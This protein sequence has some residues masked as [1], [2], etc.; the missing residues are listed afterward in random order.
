VAQF[1]NMI[2][3]NKAKSGLLVVLFILLYTLLFFAV[4]MGTAGVFLG[5]HRA[6]ETW[7]WLPVLL[8]SHAAAVGLALLVLAA[9][10]GL[11]LSSCR[12]K[13]VTHESDAELCNILQEVSLAA[14]VPAP[15]L[16]VIDSLSMNALAAGYGRRGAV[17]AVTSGLRR[18]LDRD[19]LQA[20][21]AYEVARIRDYDV[22]LMTLTAGFVGLSSLVVKVLSETYMD[23]ASTEGGRVAIALIWV[24]FLLSP[25]LLP[26]LV[27][28]PLAGRAIQRAVSRERQFLADV[29]AARLTRYPEALVRAL[30]ILSTDTEV[31]ETASPVT[32]HLCLVDPI[33]S[34]G[35]RAGGEG[36]WSAHPAIEDR[37]ARLKS[38][39]NIEG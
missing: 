20:V 18:R 4:A 1:E 7:T 9:G 16:Y 31:M 24:V 2:A 23:L 8:G 5:W 13:A 6:A 21:L 25:F 27:L 26:V 39:G 17:V 38:I 29:E 3:A 30:Q 10:P 14:G 19:E 36:D 15:S 33:L 28:A 22:Q 11:I 34:R 12:A 37:I 35:R 32:A